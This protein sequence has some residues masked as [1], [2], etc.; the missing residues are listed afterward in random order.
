M[1]EFNLVGV[2]WGREGGGA[3]DLKVKDKTNFVNILSFL[4]NRVTSSFI[5]KNHF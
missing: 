3:L 2:G 4:P 1:E 5:K